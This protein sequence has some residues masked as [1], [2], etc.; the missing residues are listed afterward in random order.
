MFLPTADR[1]RRLPQLLVIAAAIS[2]LP[3]ASVHGR[4]DPQW[5]AKMFEVTEIK[6]GSVAKGADSAI[7]LKVKNIYQE[8]IQIT[9]L[10]TG[11]GCVSWAEIS[12]SDPPP[13]Q[14]PIVIPS[15]QQRLLTLRLNTIQYDGERKSKASVFL[16][17]PVHG[18]TAVVEFPVHAFIR[19]D[20]VITPGAANFGTVDLGSGAER[21]LQIS[22]AISRNDW[23]LT[24]AKTSNPNV[25][26]ALRETLRGNGLVNY[27]LVVT[28]LPQAPV[29]TLRDQIMLVS[30]DANNSQLPILVEAK[31]EPDIAVTD[32]S[33]GALA[34]GQSKTERVIVRGRKPFKIEELYR[35]KKDSSKL[36]DDAFKVKLDKR[37]S[38]VH[39]LPVTFTA[40]DIPGVFEEDFFVKI[41]GRPQPIPF[42]ARGRVLEQTGA[43]KN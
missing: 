7:Q 14:L 29:G 6:F 41:E 26:V 21:K 10:T 13:E 15:G 31:V 5:G 9:N 27:E 24:Q 39:T 16:L 4:Q 40:P 32:L 22:Y 20:V 37:N 42:K 25:S 33:F 11:C 3:G 35:E 43:A 8:D 23:K 30:D 17:D 1:T 12:R 36:Q 19:K 2:L 18:V 34:P 28:L 38:T